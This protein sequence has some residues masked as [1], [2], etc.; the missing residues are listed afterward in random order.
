[1]TPFSLE[2]T[3]SL[4]RISHALLF[5]AVLVLMGSLAGSLQAA[6]ATEQL[7]PP[8]TL[9]FDT[10][11]NGLM[12]ISVRLNGVPA[13]FLFDTGSDNCCISDALAKKLGLTP[14]PATG[15]DGKPLQLAG[16]TLPAV[17]IAKLEFG[18]WHIT[19]QQ[20]AVVNFPTVY[21]STGPSLDGI[22]GMSPLRRCPMLLDFTRHS[23]TIFYSGPLS[24]D[25]LN[26][27]GMGG[28]VSL[29]LEGDEADHVPAC[30]VDVVNGSNRA[31][32]LLT[33]D[34][35]ATNT[36]IPSEAAQRLKLKPIATDSVGNTLYGI[37]PTVSS[38]ATSISIGGLSLSGPPLCY[39]KDKML[40]G[41]DIYSLGLDILTHFRVLLEYDQNRLYLSPNRTATST[42]S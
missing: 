16:R 39:P 12:L 2:M 17:S 33:V 18:T 31:R 20:C 6:E 14:K 27:L 11:R 26:R 32:V 30:P 22:L 8:M 10:S 25:D 5:V 34:T 15:P 41:Y 7:Y 35:G 3:M 36:M 9:P 37:I 29:P 24:A 1:M 28:A 42:K 13:T 40:P 23:I 19:D 38:R 4:N 21:T